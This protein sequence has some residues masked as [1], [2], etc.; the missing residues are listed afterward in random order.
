MKIIMMR[1]KDGKEFNEDCKEVHEQ[2][3]LNRD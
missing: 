2:L 1:V 3:F